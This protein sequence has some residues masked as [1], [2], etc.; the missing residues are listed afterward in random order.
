[1]VQGMYQSQRRS[2][3]PAMVDPLPLKIVLF[4]INNIKH[5]MPVSLSHP[6]SRFFNVIDYSVC[7]L[8]GL[9]GQV[10]RDA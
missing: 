7:K 6:A 2:M 8:K 5:L 4:C 1:M 9:H 10:Y 3:V